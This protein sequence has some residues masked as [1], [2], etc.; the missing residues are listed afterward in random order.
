MDAKLVCQTVGVALTYVSIYIFVHSFSCIISDV[1][2]VDG[3]R[4]QSIELMMVQDSRNG[5]GP[6]FKWFADKLKQPNVVE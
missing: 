3:D 4:S 2:L 6:R 1:Q 5:E